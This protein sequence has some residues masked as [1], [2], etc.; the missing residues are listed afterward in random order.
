MTVM[1]ASELLG[2]DKIVALQTNKVTAE[3]ESG[4]QASAP[5]TIFPA[6]TGRLGLAGVRAS[7]VDELVLWRVSD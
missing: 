6:H 7:W 5:L 4:L 2:H 3:E 1:P